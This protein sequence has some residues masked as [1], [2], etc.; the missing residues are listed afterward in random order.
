MGKSYVSSPS[1]TVRKCL[2]SIRREFY[3]GKLGIVLFAVGVILTLL[4][5]NGSVQLGLVLS[6]TVLLSFA[7]SLLLFDLD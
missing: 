7:L 2:L 3:F 4:L 1:K 5:G 6:G